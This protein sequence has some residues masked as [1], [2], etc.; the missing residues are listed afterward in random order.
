MTDDWCS[1]AMH[2]HRRLL[3]PVH[4]M[5]V[6]MVVASRVLHHQRAVQQQ[7][8]GHVMAACC[9]LASSTQPPSRAPRSSSPPAP[10]PVP[11]SPPPSWCHQ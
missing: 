3:L 8:S 2:V 10:A 5:A 11:R 6:P 9:S 1:Q 4:L 7:V